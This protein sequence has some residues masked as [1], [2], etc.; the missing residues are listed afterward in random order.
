MKIGGLVKKIIVVLVFMLAL[1]PRV[2]A[3]EEMV[4]EAV[5]ELLSAADKAESLEAGFSDVIKKYGTEMRQRDLLFTI[6]ARSEVETGTEA[7]VGVVNMYSLQTMQMSTSP[8]ARGLIIYYCDRVC[9]T[10]TEVQNRLEMTARQVD[11]GHVKG[12]VRRGADNAGKGRAAVVKLSDALK[13]EEHI[14]PGD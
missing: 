1:A 7:I 9:Q 12:L 13:K 3:Q 6:A 5:N 14:L 10:M 11:N 2:T 4:I 8:E